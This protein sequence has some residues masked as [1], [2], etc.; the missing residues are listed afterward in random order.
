MSAHR[1]VPAMYMALIFTGLGDKNQAFHWMN[2]AVDERTEYLIYLASEPLADPLRDDLR[3]AELANK[4]G[5]RLVTHLS[6]R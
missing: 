1:Y 5:I 3:F 4:V 6:K 2:T